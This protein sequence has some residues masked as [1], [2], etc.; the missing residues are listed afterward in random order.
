[1]TIIFK[2]AVTASG[3]QERIGPE[4]KKQSDMGNPT[5]PQKVFMAGQD[6]FVR[7]APAAG[8]LKFKG[9]PSKDEK[10]IERLQP[11]VQSV[12]DNAH[13][14]AIETG[15]SEL[16]ADHVIWSMITSLDEATKSRFSKTHPS[17][18]VA[19]NT[20]QSQQKRQWADYLAEALMPKS[21]LKSAQVAKKFKPMADSLQERM[22]KRQKASSETISIEPTLRDTMS[23]VADLI[24]HA[25]Q[26]MPYLAGQILRTNPPEGHAFYHLAQEAKKLTERRKQPVQMR[27]SSWSVGSESDAGSIGSAVS[28]LGDVLQAKSPVLAKWVHAASDKE[29]PHF[30]DDFHPAPLPVVVA[31]GVEMALQACDKPQRGGRRVGQSNQNKN[32]AS[33]QALIPDTQQKSVSR[34]QMS[35]VLN[36]ALAK[37]NALPVPN[38]TEELQTASDDTRHVFE[39][40]LH[41]PK[42]SDFSLGAFVQTLKNNAEMD[43]D[44]PEDHA[45]VGR[46]LA[47]L[48]EEAQDK[49]FEIMDQ[50]ESAC[51]TLQ[52]HGINLVRQG[53]DGKLPNVFMRQ[54]ATDRM[55]A[56]I[57]SGGNRTSLLLNA[58]SGEGKTFAVQRLAQ[59]IA[60]N[61]VPK[62]IQCT[63]LIQLDLA[64][65]I[66]G[67][68]MRG[69][70]EERA[71][72]MFDELNAYL[73]QHNDRKVLVFIDEIHMLDTDEGKTL[74]DIMKSSG[75]LERK[76]LTFIGATTPEDWRTSSLR[77][78]AAFQGRFHEVALPGFTKDEKLAILGAN[79]QQM[80]QESG[81]EIP[82]ELLEKILTQASAKWPDNSLR[83]AI[84]TLG[85]SVSLASGTSLEAAS[86]K[87]HLQHK[88]LWLDTLKAQKTMKGRFVRQ[89][90][91]TAEEVEALKTQIQ[92]LGSMPA[93]QGVTTLKDKHIREALA[94][95]TGER[96]GVMSQDELTKLRHAKGIMSQYI[97]GQSDALSAIEKG[98]RK[99]VV[100]QKTQGIDDSRPILSMLLPG[101]T[102]VGKTEV[103]KVIAK[104]FMGNHLILLDMTQ[105]MD[106]YD[107]SRLTGAAPGYVG[108]ENGGLV[109][110]VRKHPNSVIVF[111]EIEKAHPEI[112][113]VL[114]SI[115][116]EG[117]LNDNQGQSVSFRNTV[118]VL[119]S[120]LHN[121]ELTA[122]IQ[123]HR[124]KVEAGKFKDAELAAR[125]LET[126]VK[127]LLTANE[128]MGR[129]GFRKEQLGRLDAI[130]PFEPLSKSTVSDILDIRLREMNQVQELRD[131]NLEVALSSAARERLV[132]L[133]AANDVP[134]LSS[135]NDSMR[136]GHD[137]L[138]KHDGA[139]YLQ[140][141]ARDV[142]TTFKQYVF[143]KVFEDL[144]FE[145]QDL[146]N[147]QLVVDYDPATQSFP[148]RAEP[149]EVVQPVPVK[150]EAPPELD[151]FK[152]PVKKTGP[153]NKGGKR[154]GK[155]SAFA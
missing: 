102:G 145:L 27:P 18:P 58:A 7:R 153:V 14:K 115:L 97:V 98:L 48:V 80:Q 69:D 5:S 105:F 26:Q 71:T 134:T 113:N 149:M 88:K 78:D 91:K 33:L 10:L 9:F 57:N 136:V 29:P 100:R 63:P 79:A 103:A 77:K 17:Q 133:V 123:D 110:Q 144:T 128:S 90:E 124:K 138:P 30:S 154:R 114:L 81:V 131:R 117:K 60:D 116:E 87:D 24:G 84:D 44:I 74:L 94:I 151:A 46:I 72:A 66:A 93:S 16:K 150:T 89:L 1:M 3:L 21:G 54:E 140:S 51:P 120:N 155:F 85:L 67:A 65:L 118:V 39:E 82:V 70:L 122:L 83:H 15:A 53:L 125:A 73:A 99:I 109:D 56:M 96:I 152:A 137:S 43:D 86:L 47:K 32:L 62:N 147:A 8:N 104:E 49:R 13:D 59:R 148:L 146:E 92:S 6:Q 130:I 12:I 129:K 20:R 41:D 23:N 22:V 68:G 64:S 38:N 4:K 132:E 35:R 36:T 34:E 31:Q 45:A 52:E 112:F 50:F 101:P 142:R 25:H 76:N 121:E 2:P 119:T 61:D 141:G 55:L 106:K 28:H 75:V 126:Q 108:Y 11:E 143:D 139:H 40:F 37:L 19:L 127:Q 42:R 107:V 135:D 95:L 111:D